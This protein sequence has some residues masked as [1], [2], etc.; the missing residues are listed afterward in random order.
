MSSALATSSTSGGGAESSTSSTLSHSGD[1]SSGTRADNAS[2]FALTA[3][4]VRTSSTPASA[5]IPRSLA[6]TRSLRVP[7]G[8]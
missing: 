1:R 7:E 2:A 8:G 4:V 5:T 3:V 6:A